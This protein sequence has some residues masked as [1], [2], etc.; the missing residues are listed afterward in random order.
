MP[1]VAATLHGYIKYRNRRCKETGERRVDSARNI[2]I[3]AQILEGTAYIHEQALIHRD[4]KPSNIFLAMPTGGD[5]YRRQ[6]QRRFSNHWQEHGFSYDSVLTAGTLRDCMW[7]ENWVPKIGDFG[8]AS[9]IL[10]DD[11]VVDQ[12]YYPTTVFST[13]GSASSCVAADQQSSMF[14]L[15]SSSSS[16]QHCRQESTNS[17]SSSGGYFKPRPKLKRMPTTG[18]G[19]RTVSF[20]TIIALWL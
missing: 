12:C 19:T 16:S 15:S 13:S 5:G 4:L 20:K 3:F 8:L 7:D 17:L 9:T 6:H 10:D 2:E 11:K 1:N 14:F 18:V